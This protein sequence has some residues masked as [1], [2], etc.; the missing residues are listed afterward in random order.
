MHAARAR[1]RSSR[2]YCRGSAPGR[3]PFTVR[4]SRTWDLNLYSLLPKQYLL[5]TATHISLRIRVHAR[6]RTQARSRPLSL[7]ICS[8]LIRSLCCSMFLSNSRLLSSSYGLR[9]ASCCSH[10]LC[11]NPCCSHPTL[12][13]APR[14]PNSH[15]HHPSKKR[16]ESVPRNH[17]IHR[18]SNMLASTVV[19]PISSACASAAAFD[20][21]TLSSIA[22]CLLRFAR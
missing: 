22:F 7:M 12:P 17:R 3:C 18:P 6:T 11:S 19:W 4:L 13:R 20:L 14:R 21:A 2:L 15:T 1:D 9:R 8:P 16:A 10:S 5:T